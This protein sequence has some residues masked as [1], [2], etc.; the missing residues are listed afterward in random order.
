MAAI[1]APSTAPLP[2][3]LL[4]GWG[5]KPV[6]ERLL[7][8]ERQRVLRCTFPPGVGHERHYHRPHFGY[9]LSGG[10]VRIAD[11]AGTRESALLTGS[12]FTSAGVAW[13]EVLNVGDTT[14]QYL[15]VES[16]ALDAA[17]PSTAPFVGVWD[18]VSLE[19]HWPD[20]RVTEPWGAHPAGRL[21]YDADSRMSVVMM[22]EER[23]QASRGDVPSELQ[24]E[25]AGYFGGFTVDPERRLVFHHVAASLRRSESGVIERAYEF[26]DGTLVFTITGKGQGASVR[27]FQTWKRQ[28]RGD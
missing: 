9:T 4:A 3:P 2:D 11:P 5:G 12:T 1:Q 19:T 20:G 24:D 14:I 7:E 13:H 27:T 26:K 22:H 18:L 10:R 8:D 21:T 15:I 16:K 28:G 23:N 25:Q 17:N 6:C